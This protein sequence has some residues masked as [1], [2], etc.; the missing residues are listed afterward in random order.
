MPRYKWPII[1]SLFVFIA[2]SCR[3]N[4]IHLNVTYTHL[5]GLDPEDRVL[6][7]GNKAGTVAEITYLKDGTYVVELQIDKGFAGALTD[8]SAFYVVDDPAMQGHKAIEIRV[9]R[10]GGALLADGATVA[11]A[12]EAERLEY[13]MRKTLMNGVDYLARQI[14]KLKQDI[15]RIP[16]SE[17]YRQLE[18]ELKELASELKR[19]EK[20]ARERIK[21][22]W[23]PKLEQEL[24]KLKKRLRN[25]GREDELEP[26]EEEVERIRHI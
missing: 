11:G 7:E 24:E 22:E 2:I 4:V 23:L 15:E 12:S 10:D 25:W 1:I 20:E 5:S 3:S 21:R 13:L 19:S 18:R 14:D 6:V 26:L 16:D 17:A 8:A 9:L